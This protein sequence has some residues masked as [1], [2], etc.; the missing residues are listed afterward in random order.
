MTTVPTLLGG[1]EAYVT[2][3]IK[4]PNAKPNVS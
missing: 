1:V 2:W 4:A 3:F